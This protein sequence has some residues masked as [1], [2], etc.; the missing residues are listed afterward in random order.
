MVMALGVPV[1]RDGEIVAVLCVNLALDTLTSFI[2]SLSEENQMYA[3]R[4]D[5]CF[6]V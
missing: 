2:G 6:S 1:I 5:A 4:A 3:S